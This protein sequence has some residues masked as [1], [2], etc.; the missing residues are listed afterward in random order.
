M[1]DPIHTETSILAWVGNA[2]ITVNFTVSA[3]KSWNTDFSNSEWM[4]STTSCKLKGH[5]FSWAFG[6]LTPGLT[7]TMKV[8]GL[9]NLSCTQNCLRKAWEKHQQRLPLLFGAFNLQLF[10]PGMWLS[11]VAAMA[12]PSCAVCWLWPADRLPGL[13]LELPHSL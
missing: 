12:M 3:L 1:V 7:Q 8:A 5:R 10:V 2:L 9:G 6:H 4:N 11:C 13:T